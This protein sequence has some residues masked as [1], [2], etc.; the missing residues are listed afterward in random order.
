MKSKALE[1]SEAVSQSYLN[2]AVDTE[3]KYLVPAADG[4][5]HIKAI[6]VSSEYVVIAPVARERQG[7]IITPNADTNI[8]LIVGWGVMV[9]EQCKQEFPLGTVVRFAGTP[10]AELTGEFSFYGNVQI[11]LLRYTSILAAVSSIDVVIEA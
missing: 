8:G 3:S 11:F 5:I 4:K 10:V 6:K 9:P 1:A 7:I 2:R